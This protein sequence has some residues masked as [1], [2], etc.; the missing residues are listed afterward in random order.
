MNALVGYTGFVG[1]NLAKHGRFDKLFNSKNIG[2]ATCLCP[3]I[4]YY[5]GLPAEKFLADKF[6]EKDRTK[7]DEAAQN[8]V[9]I[10]AKRVVLISTVD[11]YGVTDNKSE[12]MLFSN[13]SALPYGKNRLELE[14]FVA[15]NFENHHI[16]RLPGLFGENLKKNFIYD[17]ISFVPGMLTE[18]KMTEIGNIRQEIY[19]MYILQDNGFYKLDPNVDRE[20]ARELFKDV[21][22][23]ALNFTDSRAVFQFYNLANLYRDI[24]IAIQNDIK[25]LNIA[26]E[27]ISAADLHL[28][29]SGRGFKNELAKTPPYYNFKSEHYELFD[30]KDGYLY[31]TN[32]VLSDIADFVKE[33]V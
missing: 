18:Q 3:D 23:S 20:K 19:S 11:V 14:H 2:E 26:S 30:G 12:S 8:I 16:I 29:L 10:N 21:G 17:Y 27:P 25:V 7:T 22:F 24:E 4:L 32:Q 15:D 33:R 6:P 5:S 31:T 28:Y 9:N 13:E 1:S